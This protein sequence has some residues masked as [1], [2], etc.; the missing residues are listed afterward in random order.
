MTLSW[1]KIHLASGLLAF[2]TGLLAA[3]PL[4][5]RMAD[6]QAAIERAAQLPMRGNSVEMRNEAQRL[7][8]LARESA[9]A[10]KGKD[11]ILHAN[12][13]GAAAELAVARYRYNL[14]RYEIEN[15]TSR[16]TQL[17]RRMLVLPEG[18]TR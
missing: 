9:L 7:L 18:N 10:R 12:E 14:L 15:K 13:A 2:S 6:A 1:T 5:G 11:A 16:N 8:A 3:E 17:R 4:D